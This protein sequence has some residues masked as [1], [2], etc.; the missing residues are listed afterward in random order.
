MTF[1]GRTHLFSRLFFSISNRL[2][3]LTNR[4][5]SF[6]ILIAGWGMMDDVS[7]RLKT[8]R[9]NAGLSQRALASRA[10]VPSSSIS[11]IEN[12]KVSP[13][14]SSLKRLLDA[15]GVS[16]S[17]FFGEDEPRPRQTV[18]RKSEMPQLGRGEISYR[19]VGRNLRDRAIQML[20]E[21]Y[22][23]GGSSGKVPLVHQG[24]E[25]GIII[26]GRLEVTVDGKTE[27][28][29]PGDGYLFDST[30]PHRFHN[31]GEVPCI[32]VSACTPPSF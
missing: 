32:V 13:S 30:R 4:S 16:L 7:K 22:A 28:L 20:F 18:F 10:G 12:R 9:E 14:V 15:L 19:Q 27:V 26:E 25:A 1:S 29:G 6:I 17:E 5:I 31:R 24:E 8:Y 3:L 21:E 2:I 23:P 11:L